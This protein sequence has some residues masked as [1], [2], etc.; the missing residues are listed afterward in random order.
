MMKNGIIEFC[1]VSLYN[2]RFDQ[3]F[4]ATEQIRLKRTFKLSNLPIVMFKHFLLELYSTVHGRVLYSLMCLEV[5]SD[6]IVV[7]KCVGQL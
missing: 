1:P 3:T 4:P 7:S 6:W 2:Q 5:D